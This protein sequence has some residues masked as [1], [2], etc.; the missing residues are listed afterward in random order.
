M[1]Q[2]T[3]VAA[4]HLFPRLCNWTP[5]TAILGSISSAVLGPPALDL[6]SEG[7]LHATTTIRPFLLQVHPSPPPRGQAPGGCRSPASSSREPGRGRR[8]QDAWVPPPFSSQGEIPLRSPQAL[9]SQN[10]PA[11]EGKLW[12]EGS[13]R[14]RRTELRGAAG[15][16][17]ERT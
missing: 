13:G 17:G 16:S 9:G 8:G 4:G 6:S 14:G 5:P 2:P 10:H 3:A 15:A 11:G 12:R 1:F 7:L